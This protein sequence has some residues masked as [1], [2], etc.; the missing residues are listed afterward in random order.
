MNRTGIVGGYICRGDGLSRR[1]SVGRGPS[2]PDACLDSGAL[3]WEI[4]SVEIIGPQ[5]FSGS[6][7]RRPFHDVRELPYVARVCPV[8]KQ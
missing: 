1:H 8:L 6:G 4:G 7:E 2:P 3:A 5:F